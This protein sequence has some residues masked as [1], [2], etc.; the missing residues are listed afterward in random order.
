MLLAA[1]AINFIFR[2][3][4]LAIE[5]QIISNCTPWKYKVSLYFANY[6]TY[7]SQK[8]PGDKQVWQVMVNKSWCLKLDPT[9]PVVV[10]IWRTWYSNHQ[11]PY[12]RCNE[13]DKAPTSASALVKYLQFAC[14]VQ[15]YKAQTWKWHCT[16]RRW[17]KVDVRKAGKIQD[18]WV[19][20]NVTTSVD[21]HL[22]KSNMKS[23]SAHI[24]VMS[25]KRI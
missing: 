15:C 14:N 21:G 8:A 7:Q 19:S 4:C 5:K 11:C 12:Q 25:I 10:V 24:F 6:I 1:N 13:T 17:K 20:C 16:Q 23:S 2:R 3:F 18:I 9:L 22:T